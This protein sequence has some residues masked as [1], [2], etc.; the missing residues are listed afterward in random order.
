MQSQEISNS[1]KQPELQALFTHDHKWFIFSTN[2][3]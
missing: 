1:F 2:K 3:D